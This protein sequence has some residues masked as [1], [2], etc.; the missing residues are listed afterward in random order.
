MGAILVK[1][2]TQGCVVRCEKALFLPHCEKKLMPA[3]AFVRLGC[4]IV[5]EDFDKVSLYSEKGDVIFSGKE[6]DGLYYFHSETVHSTSSTFFGLPLNTTEADVSAPDFSKRFLEAHWSFGHL[7][8]KKLRKLFRL[9]K[10]DDPDCPACTIATSRK[11][12]LSKSKYNRST[13]VN[14]RKHVDIGFTRNSEICF[15]LV[16]DDY[17][18]ESF[19]DVL[20]SKADCLTSFQTL[21]KCHDND[22]APYRLAVVRTD[23]EAIYTTPVWD[24]YC[25]QQGYARE[26]SGRYRHD[27]HGVVERAMQAIGVPFRCMMIQG[28]APECDAPDALRHAN[29]IRNNSPTKANNGWSPRE[30]NA[31][32]R[33]PV[34][35][36]LLRGPL[37][38]LI[39]AHVYEE[40]RHKN[41]PRGIP[42]VYLGYD[43]VN[44]V[45]LVKEWESGKRYF[46]ADVTFHPHTFPY[47][48]NPTRSLKQIHAFDDLAPHVLVPIDSESKG[49]NEGKKEGK[50]G[51]DTPRRSH[52]VTFPSDQA[53]RNFPDVDLPPST[54]ANNHFIHGFGPDPN[55]WP[56]A[57]MS[58]YGNEWILARLNEQNRF[59]S[60]GV[61]ELVL[62]AQVV[63]AGKKIFKPRPVMKIKVNPPSLQHPHG[64]IDKFKYRLTIAAFTKS[65]I[66]GIDYEEKYASTVR[67][68]SIKVLLAIACKENHDIVLFDI[69]SFFLYAPLLDEVYMEQADG[70]EDPDKPK[71]LWVCK[72]KKSMY[73]LPQSPHNA[74]K[75]LKATLI[76]GGVFK[77]TSSDDCIYVGQEQ[78]MDYSALGAHV[79]DLC[80]I[81]TKSGLEKI[82]KTLSGKFDITEKINPDV[83]TGVQIERDRQKHWLKIHQTAYTTEM[84]VKYGMAECKGADTPIDPG[85]ARELMLLPT[86]EKDVN[87]V[88]AYQTFVGELIWLRKTRLD[89]FFLIS[90]L[91]RFLQNATARH[92]AIAKGRPLQFLKRTSSYGLVFAPGSGEWTLSGASDSDLAGDLNTA[93]STLGHCAHLGA[94]G[95]VL[96]SCGLERKICTSTGQGETYAVQALV[97]HIEWLRA[98]LNELGHA[99][100]G[101]T[102]V[103]VDNN[104]VLKQSTKAVNHTMAKHYRIA[105]AYIRQMVDY[106]VVKLARVGTEEN[107][108]DIFT[109]ALHGPAFIKHQFRIMGPQVPWLWLLVFVL[110]SLLRDANLIHGIFVIA[111]F[112]PRNTG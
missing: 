10:G 3:S 22:H 59:K 44:N 102:M 61:L 16:I 71:S 65:L 26:F 28:N 74:Q 109:K 66:Q 19:L 93:R 103:Y 111:L 57:E 39:F 49:E 7:H 46:T 11:Q 81:G 110:N 108:S 35:Q 32:R 56:E 67:W 84:L 38:C 98:F 4:K 21:Q 12:A 45:Y 9:G 37:F 48:S 86:D 95:A 40:E 89:L 105:Q 24:L 107:Y 2:L 91:S 27:Q 101:P 52:R 41:A 79:D 60:H 88:K 55:D 25:E 73:G 70:W 63:A 69:S 15:Q 90:L 47:R 6:V 64:S 72:L 34:N 23:C 97:K 94:F 53:L 17:T 87:V 62:R 33:L 78:G 85:T 80:A 99:M 14:H 51:E 58:K 83:I 29:V 8:F 100:D 13:R 76:Q 30:K 36:R 106:G 1:S 77:A 75:E 112:G 92:L 20:T 96:T 31:G 68:D 104:G 42:S 50:Y 18:R 54:K 5:L 43:S 82:R